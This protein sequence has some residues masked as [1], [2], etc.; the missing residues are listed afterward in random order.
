MF[1]RYTEKG[2]R[3]IFFAR[4]EASAQGAAHIEAEHL[5]LGLMRED[6]QLFA[7]LLSS[8]SNIVSLAEELRSNLPPQTPVST[9]VDLPFGIMAKRSLAYAAEEAEQLEHREISP[10][11]LLL[12]LLREDSRASK[13][14]VSHGVTLTSA[15]E[16]ITNPH[17]STKKSAEVIADLRREFA[18][19]LQRLTLEIEPATVFSLGPS[20]GEGHS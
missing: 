17:V 19:S 6:K 8:G 2:R 7:T 9:T 4:Y 12:G 10:G 14:L 16:K 1:E 15:R 18:G 20:R 11:H 3:A 13:F 5:L